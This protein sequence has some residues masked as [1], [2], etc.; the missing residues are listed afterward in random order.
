MS[1][2]SA[3]RLDLLRFLEKVQLRDL[4]RTRGWIVAEEQRLT[5]QAARLPQAPPPDWELETDLG[6]HPV[7][8]HAGGCTMGGKGWRMR[9]ISRQAALRAL[10]VDKI[11]PCPYCSPD[12]LLG[13]LD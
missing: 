10:G 2:N 6:R 7:R 12:T 4:E 3:P 1:D 8:V 11:P 9:P 5:E 13:V